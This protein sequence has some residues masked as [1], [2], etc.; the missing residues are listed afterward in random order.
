ML[1]LYLLEIQHEVGVVEDLPEHVS[2]EALDK[3]INVLIENHDREVVI[4]YLHAFQNM[5][6]AGWSSLEKALETDERVQFD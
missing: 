5:N 1:F 2:E 4:L 6:D 3:S